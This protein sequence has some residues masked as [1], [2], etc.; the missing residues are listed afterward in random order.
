MSHR[1][2]LADF[3]AESVDLLGETKEVF[4]IGSGPAIILIPEI[5]GI[6]PEHADLARRLAA[7]GYTV[8]SPS[9]FGEPGRPMSS[10]HALRTIA[11]AC[12]A[13]EFAAFATGSTR[14]IT[15][16]LRALAE[17]E[18]AACGGRGVGV[19]GMC[20]TGGFGLA[21]MLSD[22]VVAPVLSQPSLPLPLGSAR[23]ADYGLDPDDLARI[24]ER[25]ADG[26]CVVGLRFT[27]DRAV[28]A[29][30]F[31]SLRRDLGDAFTAF[32]IDSGPGNEHGIAK[33]AHSVLTHDF[34][35]APG[36]PT[37]VAYDHV[38]EFFASRLPG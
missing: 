27:E 38:L 7:Q 10:G 37:R 15:A 26:A 6:T 35:D 36:H 31:A 19:I 18:H 28:P 23:R 30:R 17:R 12:V 34:V 14:P 9:V 20:F 33:S 16:W 8:V 32:E 22:S 21:M 29:E 2:A 13:R 5:P 25:T 3:S 24:L 1:D 11:R 4:R